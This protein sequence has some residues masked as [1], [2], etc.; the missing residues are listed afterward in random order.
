[1]DCSDMV[2]LLLPLQP[3]SDEEKKR[4]RL[5]ILAARRQHDKIIKQS[6]PY[7][8]IIITD[9]LARMEEQFRNLGIKV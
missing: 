9:R 8:A 7:K 1:M 6:C 5:A 3:L 4:F 2:R